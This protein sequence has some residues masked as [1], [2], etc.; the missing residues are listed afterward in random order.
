MYAPSLPIS[1]HF[2]VN[3]PLLPRFPH[4]PPTQLF[5]LLFILMVGVWVAVFL[6]ANNHSCAD[7][8]L[9][10]HPPPPPLPL[11]TQLFP[12]LFILM[13]GVWVAMFLLANNYDNIDIFLTEVQYLTVVASINLNAP[14]APNGW[15]GWLIK[16]YNLS[17]FDP[18][19]VGPNCV[20]TYRFP[21][22]FVFGILIFLV[23]LVVYALH[24]CLFLLREHIKLLKAKRAA[25]NGE[26]SGVGQLSSTAAKQRRQEYYNRL[27]GG[28]A[29]WLDV[30]YM[31]ILARVLPVFQSQMVGDTKVRCGGV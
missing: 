7:T 9:A 27:V 2:P 30:C 18:D 10:L 17:V 1:C 15:V 12:L 19:V 6:L 31:G 26:T 13:I 22:Q 20:L 28:V 14:A 3:P 4:F 21:Q 8:C 16:I 5:L 25:E 23:G 24:W 29:S 11:S